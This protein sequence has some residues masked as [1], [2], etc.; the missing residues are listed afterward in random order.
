MKSPSPR[1]TA[2]AFYP[3][4]N[5]LLLFG[6]QDA[7]GFYH[8]TWEYQGTTW[9]R[10]ST[11]DPPQGRVGEVLATKRVGILM[12]GGFGG[13]SVRSDTVNLRVREWHRTTIV[14]PPP[15]TDMGFANTV[16]RAAVVLFGGTDGSASFGDTWVFCG[17]ACT[18]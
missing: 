12:Y 5:Q 6:G 3:I 2:T 13:Q 4:D 14:G 15:R 17:N 11:Q 10:I 7:T 9:H 1:R 18:P 8:D 16:N